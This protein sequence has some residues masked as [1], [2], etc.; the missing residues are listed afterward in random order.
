MGYHL[1]RPR[2]ALTVTPRSLRRG[3]L[4]LVALGCALIVV[5]ALALRHGRPPAATGEGWSPGAET[6]SE[7]VPTTSPAP[8][9]PEA[10]GLNRWPGEPEPERAPDENGAA[11]DEP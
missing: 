6:M 2:P 4:L 7:G 3:T 9:V 1:V 11:R 5:V 10:E 8:A